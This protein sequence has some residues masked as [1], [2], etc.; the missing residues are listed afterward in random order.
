MSSNTIHEPQQKGKIVRRQLRRPALIGALLLALTPVLAAQNNTQEPITPKAG[1]T[2][3]F[4]GKVVP[5]ADLLKEIGSRLDK[6]AAPHWM[7]LVTKD[8]KV[9]PL[10][11]D[12]GSKMFFTDP[13]VRNRPMRLTGRLFADTHL[14]QVVNI[15]S[16]KD[17]KLYDIYYWCDVCTIRRNAGGVCECCG[18]PMELREYPLDAK[19]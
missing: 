9:Y 13:K 15:H 11:R 14:L 10:I 3:F 8:G 7:A 18:A 2:Q 16:I 12:D 4:E 17:G 1:K 19:K 5:L 6:D